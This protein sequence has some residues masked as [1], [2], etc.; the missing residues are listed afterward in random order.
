MHPTLDGQSRHPRAA[1]LNWELVTYLVTFSIPFLLLLLRQPPFSRESRLP[2]RTEILQ[3]EP[4]DHRGS[5]DC[6]LYTYPCLFKKTDKPMKQDI[7]ACR[8]GK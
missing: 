6:Y 4:A 7:D 8:R 5:D 2:I 3:T 1:R